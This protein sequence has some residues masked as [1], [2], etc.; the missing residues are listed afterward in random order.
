MSN[1]NVKAP[2]LPKNEEEDNVV[3]MPGMVV[4]SSD[5]L[6]GPHCDRAR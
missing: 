4:S 3:S 1:V 2:V 6:S 5:H